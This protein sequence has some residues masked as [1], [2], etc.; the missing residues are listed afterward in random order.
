MRWYVQLKDWLGVVHD[1]HLVVG[2]RD[3]RVAVPGGGVVGAQFAVRRRHHLRTSTR[4][5]HRWTPDLAA[6]A[7]SVTL[8]C[9]SLKLV[10]YIV[11]FTNIRYFK[12]KR[13]SYRLA[14]FCGYPIK[15]E[16]FSDLKSY[17]MFLQTSPLFELFTYTMVMADRTC[18]WE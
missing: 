6:D 8:R 4:V 12:I 15:N 18:L 2:L 3:G 7:T 13:L 9:F 5:N 14:R 10:G 16:T 17:K 11:T 1:V